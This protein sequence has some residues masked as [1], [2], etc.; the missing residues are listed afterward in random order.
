LIELDVPGALMLW[1]GDGRPGESVIDEGETMGFKQQCG[2][3]RQV[4]GWAPTL[5]FDFQAVVR[6]GA[7]LPLSQLSWRNG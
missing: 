7:P 6:I 2:R 4:D 3:V 1:E 5:P